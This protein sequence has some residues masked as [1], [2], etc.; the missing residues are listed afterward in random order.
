M[1]KVLTMKKIL[2]LDLGTNSIGWA[3]ITS[4]SDEQGR[5]QFKEINHCGSRII[6]LD[7]ATLGDFNRGNTISQT[8][9]R[10][11]FRGIRRLY[12]RAN[13]RRERLN[14]VLAILGWLPKHYSD[15]LDRYG[16]FLPE[17]EPKLAWYKD[18]Q[19][20]MHFVFQNAFSEMLDDFQKSNPDYC[21]SGRLI[22]YDWTLYYLR[23]KA[24]TRPV[25]KQ[26]LAWIL[27]SFNQKRGYNHAR[28]EDEDENTQESGKIVEYQPLRVIR[29]VD[30]GE[31]KGKGT[32]H[33][34][35]LENGM[36][37][38]RVFT[39]TPNWIDETKDFIVTTEK[40]PDGSLKKDKEGNI[41]YS[42][43][44]PNPE[45]WTLKKKK[46]EGDI[47]QSHKTVGEYIYDS[48]LQ[49]PSQKIRGSLVHTV[50]RSFYR[51]ELIRILEK[52]KEFLADLNNPDLY[53]TCIQ[54]LYPGNTAYR[55]SISAR[56]FTYLFVDDILFYQRPLKSKKSLIDDCPYETREYFDP[57]DKSSKTVPVKCIPKSHP[58]YQEFR[59]WQFIAN[60]RIYEKETGRDVTHDLLPDTEHIAALYEW[61]SDRESI[62]QKNLLASPV[63]GLKKSEQALV[64]WNYVEDKA[65]PCNETRAS[66]LKYLNKAGIP[67]TFLSRE[68]EEALWHIFYSVSNK[69]EIKKA[70]KRF[71]TKEEQVPLDCVESFV[72]ALSK[73]PPYDNSYGAYSL[74]AIRK[75]LP[76]MRAGKYW[77]ESS[78]LS[79]KGT[80][81]RINKIITGEYDPSIQDRV[82]QQ[83][84]R[85]HLERVTDFQNLPVWLACYIVYNR[86]S[87]AKD[88][89]K[90]E[91]P[92][93]IDTYLRSFKQH[94]LHNPIV[95]SV[96]TE[97]LRTVRDIWKEEGRIDEIHIELGR[98][99][100]NPADKRKIDLERQIRNE[101]ANLRIRAML[102]EFMNPEFEV[103]NVRPHSPGQQ[104]ILR[105][106]EET[107][108]NDNSLG[109]IPDD[110]VQTL[111][112]FRSLDPA[113]RPTRS[114]VLRYKLW[115]EQRYRSPYTG[116]I[117]P[118]GKLFTPAY[119]IEHIIPQS[120]YFDDS[121]SNKV[122][123]ES[124][125]NKEKG[126]LL[127]MAFIKEKHGMMVQL[128]N[129]RSV[130]V[131]EVAEYERFVKDH[132]GSRDAASKKRNLLADEIPETFIHRQLNDTRYISKLVKSLLSNIV[133]EKD[134]QDGISRNVIT[135]T[136]GITDRLKKDWGIND[137]W[138]Q[139][140]L[141]RF[142][143]MQT[144]CPQDVFVT[145]NQRGN[146]VPCIPDVYKRG[147][148]LKR[149]DHRHHAMDAIVIACATRNMVSYLNN[150]SACKGARISRF[151]LQH[152][153]CD[154]VRQD[155]AGNYAWVIRKPGSDFIPQV[156]KSLEDIIVSF[157][158]NLR[159]INK[160][161]NRYQRIVDGKKIHVPQTKGESWAIRKSMHKDTVF[162]EINLRLVKT[163]SLNDALKQPE[164]IVRKD[165]KAF[166]KAFG[167][168]PAKTIKAKLAET[169]PD[170]SRLE[171]YYF[172]KETSDQYYA[173]R[174]NLD[175]SFD[176]AKIEN[177]VT[178]SGI[179]KILLKHLAL[180]SGDPKCAFSP[181][182]IEAMNRNLQALNDGKAH[183]PI[184]KVR[185]YEKANKFAV[186]ETGNKAKKFVEAAK[187][188]NLFYAVY[189]AGE[190]QRTF[191]SIPLN[192]AILRE[193]SGDA[194][195]PEKDAQGNPL[196][197]YLSPNDLVYLPTPD[198]LE[199]GRINQPIDR[200]R[201]YK[202]V[203]SSGRQC[204]FLPQSTSAG[205]I[206]KQEYTT[207]NK[208]ERAITGEM[209]KEICIPLKV[210]RLGKIIHLNDKT[211]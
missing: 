148:S 24:L 157:K 207:L 48:L 2:G 155:D 45:D 109:E 28:G 16:K 154:K 132:Y 114:E 96:V 101:N 149:L 178:D 205:I 88:T 80:S 180:N 156:R 4:E 141:P 111:D 122:I 137:L 174:K 195:V 161:S 204:F 139:L 18:T 30:T 60:L 98:E 151:D 106:Y 142:E 71:A 164:R 93:D 140:L 126:N 198:E 165:I 51:E 192:I 69:Q 63:L 177:S 39:E 23:K 68:K 61:M 104:E 31:K 77:E 107:A 188:T 78:L 185:C 163:V 105:I 54:A 118:L 89:A 153:L 26:E 143:R 40:N 38:K 84:D 11:R 189:D 120:V 43:R 81:A 55:S 176:K 90:W 6:P 130:R 124:A 152:L 57:K 85:F 193:K 147:N 201:I 15:C 44:L 134:E 103:E 128:G 34:I 73:M 62:D 92:D 196:L 49:N 133:R 158:Q 100:K 27:L 121:F 145:V 187:G 166:I 169:F 108:L 97:T 13:L 208:M 191:E 110:I 56:N 138:K 186:G 67:T 47:Q 131:F 210:D 87:E 125:V 29:I 172:S 116:E 36:V 33:L 102:T 1:A 37:Y 146:R 159:V 20:K 209:I 181:E 66:I 162:G 75:L 150:E 9:E 65:Y 10:T 135:C 41:K 203:S 199:T 171:I 95:E 202:M 173:T 197:F 112:K 182:G 170:L 70:L 76:L 194:P 53:Q 58:A 25:S 19:G 50:E 99:M 74:K 211:L 7:Q 117:I 8:A 144:K 72:G 17:T 5:E 183:Q 206:D 119:E 94:S 82:R 46:T 22:P 3:T 59:L 14:R 79:D 127:G 91:T 12:E 42:L 167:S 184:I 160:T 35:T 83:S 168:L 136:G 129:G 115:L 190:G 86:H 32:W 52:Q 123:C 113:K 175:D 200:D 21:A 64:R 179:Q